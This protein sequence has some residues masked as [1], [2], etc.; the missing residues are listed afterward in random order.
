MKALSYIVA[1]ILMLVI[2]IALSGTAYLYMSGVFT[3]TIQGIEIAD[4]YCSFGE[5]TLKIK[6]IGTAAI[7]SLDIEQTNPQDDF[8]TPSF[9]GT[10]EPGKTVEYKDTCTGEQPRKCV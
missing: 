1:S 5:V 10:I 8:L 2:T 6:N 9:Q 7:T 4:A 3:G